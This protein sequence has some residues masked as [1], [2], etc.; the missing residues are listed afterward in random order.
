MEQ[1]NSKRSPAGRHENIA[2]QV[3]INKLFTSKK[4]KFKPLVSCKTERLPDAISIVDMINAYAMDQLPYPATRRQVDRKLAEMGYGLQALK[5]QRTIFPRKKDHSSSPRMAASVQYVMINL[6]VVKKSNSKYWML[7]LKT[8]AVP[9]VMYPF[10]FQSGDVKVSYIRDAVDDL[11]KRLDK[12]LPVNQRLNK[13]RCFYI[14]APSD[15][16]TKLITDTWPGKELRVEL[17]PLRQIFLR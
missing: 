8:N 1:S 3:E 15:I 11:A 7:L 13:D 4:N 10:S 6:D 2:L 16:C 17:H 12:T 5:G 9:V 14:L